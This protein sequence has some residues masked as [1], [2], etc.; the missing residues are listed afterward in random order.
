M[1]YVI[2]TLCTLSIAASAQENPF[3][4]FPLR[5]GSRWIYE[6]ESKSG[7]RNRPDVDGW[8]SEETITRLVNIPEGIVV[9]RE[10]KEQGSHTGQTVGA[11]V[12]APNGQIRESAPRIAHSDYL[13]TRD[14]EPYLV[15][16]SCVYVIAEGWDQ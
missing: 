4:W 8:T 13:V 7:D 14:R 3:A 9:L 1:R 2:L 11:E 10:V 5:V 15:H 16:G 12:T 6:H